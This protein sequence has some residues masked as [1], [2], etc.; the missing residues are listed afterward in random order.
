MGDIVEIV[1][2]RGAAALNG[3][4][5]KIVAFVEETECFGVKMATLPDPKAI[6]A[7]NL[8]KIDYDKYYDEVD[9]DYPDDDDEGYVRICDEFDKY[10]E[11]DR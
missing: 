3:R 4:H 8:R 7:A 1:N 6:K 10:N 11:D 9:S 5:G 2:L